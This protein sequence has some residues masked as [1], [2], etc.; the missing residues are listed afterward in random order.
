MAQGVSKKHNPFDRNE[1]FH[2]RAPEGWVS[3]L[4]LVND[5]VD[6]SRSFSYYSLL[7]FVNARPDI[8]VWDL[9]DLDKSVIVANCGLWDY[10]SNQTAV[11]IARTVPRSV[12]SLARIGSWNDK[13][14]ASVKKEKN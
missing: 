7:P 10:I 11:D 9:T 1:T 12:P 6:V 5:E 13:E 3:P 2:I 14:D 4:G 8:C